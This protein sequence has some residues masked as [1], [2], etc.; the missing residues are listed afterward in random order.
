MF[1][2][3]LE[4]VGEAHALTLH[5]TSREALQN[6]ILRCKENLKA[7]IQKIFRD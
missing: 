6:E 1:L 3:F 7:I 5:V 2:D 4:V